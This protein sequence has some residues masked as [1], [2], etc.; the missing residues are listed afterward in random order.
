MRRRS[1]HYEFQRRGIRFLKENA[2]FRR[3]VLREIDRRGPLL[4]R[5]LEDHSKGEP[6]NHRWYGNRRVGIML[7][8]LHRRGEIA[9]V[10]RQGGE[11][12]WDLAER[13]YPETER[14]APA[15]A[16]RP[17]EEK[18]GRAQGVRLERDRW[19]GYP[20]IDARPVPD[21]A[22]LLSP[23]DRLVYDRDRADA[24]W[25]FRHRLEMSVPKGKRE[26]GYYVPATARRRRCCRPR[27][28]RLRRE[29]ASAPSA[30]RM[31]RHVTARRGARRARGLA[32]SG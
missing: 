24:L 25:D 15:K 2:G 22:V 18:R 20:G 7:G 17:L 5:D 29:D 12:L 26:F 30:R 14:V 4:S 1:T 16:E 10:G 11:R 13:W 27:R 9:I 3:Y 23:F 8:L 31:G 28:A 6:R 21:R 19:I 32:R